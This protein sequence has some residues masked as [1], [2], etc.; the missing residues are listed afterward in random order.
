MTNKTKK[1]SSKSSIRSPKK[2][3]IRS[4]KKS[5]IRSPKKSSIR[6]PKK[7]IAL[8]NDFTSKSPNTYS[9]NVC[10]KEL[11]YNS[12]YGPRNLK[13]HLERHNRKDYIKK[14]SKDV[15]DYFEIL[16]DIN[17][18]RCKVCDKEMN[19]TTR[20]GPQN[21]RTHLKIHEKRSSKKLPRLSKKSSRKS[22]KKSS[23]RTKKSSK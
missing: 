4:S 1:F 22:S 2:S 13:E 23:R 3:S 5:S 7:S 18:A 9:C 19:Y 8:W 10:N 12:R 14:T 17:K 15:W 20:V 16:S 11:S 6:S 21:L